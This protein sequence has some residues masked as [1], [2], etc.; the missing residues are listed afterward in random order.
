M[1]AKV[2]LLP[3]LCD[4]RNILIARPF[5]VSHVGRTFTV[6]ARHEVVAAAEG[7]HCGAGPFADPRTIGV[8]R[9]LLL[10]SQPLGTPCD[11]AALRAWCEPFEAPTAPLLPTF[12]DDKREGL[13]GW[14]VGWIEG[15][16]VDRNVLAR[17]LEVV[18]DG[19]ARIMVPKNARTMKPLRLVGDGWQI[20]LA[21]LCKATTTAPRFDLERAAAPSAAL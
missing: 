16:A 18:G 9:D 12:D 21:G 11:V 3:L 2:D 20:V 13:P 17:A 19:P 6:A 15:F 10:W 1:T 5:L 7:V 4:S 8:A 14:R